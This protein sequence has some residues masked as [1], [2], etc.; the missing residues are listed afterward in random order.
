MTII[1]KRTSSN[2]QRVFDIV[3]YQQ[4]KYPNANALNYYTG[5]TWH[6]YSIHEVQKKS[7]A[8][9]CWF[10]EQGHQPGD[11]IIFVPVTGSADWIILDLACQQAGLIVVPV[12][13]TAHAPEIE[14]IVRETEARMCITA[15]A[16]LYVKFQ[17]VIK[18]S[19][20]QVSF[21]HL[22]PGEKGFFKP[23]TLAKG[24]DE[25]LIKL[26][27]IRNTI[28]END[29]LTIMYTSG[30]S[31]V[32]KG[33]MLTHHNVVSSIKSILTLLPLEPKHRVLSFLPFSHIFERV[34]T[35]AYMAFG[36]A[37]YF[38]QHKDTFAHDFRTVRP[39]FCTSVPR[40]LEKMYDFMLEQTLQRNWLKRTV[41]RWAMETGKLYRPGTLKPMLLIK[42][43]IARSL[44]LSQWRKKLGGKIRY[45]VVGAASLRPE[46]GRLFSAAGIFVAEG[47]GMT[48]TAPFISVNRFEP[49]LNRFGTVGMAIP[50]VEIKIDNP[51]E[52]GE[53]EIL[54]KGNNVMKGYFKRPELNTEV[55][56]P[57]GWFRTGD[58]GK[59]VYER[60]LK[61]TDRKKDIFK[62]S[63]G[64]YIAPLPLQNHFMQSSF[65][66]RC[67]IIGFQRPYVTALIVPNFE[68]LEK[69]C[70]QE[71]IH[72]TA[73]EFMV[74][75][76]KVR[77]KFK[78]EIALFNEELPNFERV[79]DFVLC[80]QD[81]S[82]ETGELTTT[83]KPVR[84]LLMDHYQKEIDRMYE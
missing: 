30:S 23:I 65:I 40:V 44:V 42:L 4:Q 10:I 67:L 29:V 61:I 57:E 70:V 74:Y 11:K 47:Y 25:E 58:V 54:V 35:Y 33:V 24:A 68:W 53:G 37:I 50:G 18:N 28:T 60:F 8:I 22:Q 64:K 31:G 78:Q 36:V 2:F 79:K 15:D 32:P 13:P 16:T 77:E 41:I 39:H 82:V 7:E 1:T 71:G 73:P 5:A 3:L 55:F 56:T 66:Q 27:S 9:A 59:I 26:N 69:W 20:S 49:G 34:A 12:H 19:G 80:H 81:W 17:E 84:H 72:W 46:I 52:E 38:S 63:A 21:H 83:L 75:N 76:I 6:G 43:A 48:E 14:A 62:T 45:M 51:N